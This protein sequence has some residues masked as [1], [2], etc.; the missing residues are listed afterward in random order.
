M[1]EAFL[2]PGFGSMSLSGGLRRD[3]H[4]AAAGAE[5]LPINNHLINS[6]RLQIHGV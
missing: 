2:L 3:K 4:V 1:S 6:V 5:A